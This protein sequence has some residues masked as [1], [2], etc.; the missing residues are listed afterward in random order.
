VGIVFK[1][2]A[3]TTLA[4][5]ITDTATSATVVDGSVFPSLGAG[6]YFFCT[7]DTGTQNEIVKVTARSGNTLTIVRAQDNTTAKAFSSGNAAELRVTAGVLENIQENIAAKSA[8]QTI[9]STTTA[10]SAT[11][12]D[13]GI[14]PGVEA[15]ASVF[16][17]GVYQHHDTFSFSGSTLTFDAAPVDGTALEVIVDNLINLQSSNLSVDTFTAADVGGNPQTDFTLSDVPGAET[18]LIVFVDGVFQNQDSYTFSNNTL[19]MTDGVTADRVVTVYIINPVNIGTPSDGTITSAK[20]SGDITFPGDIT[21]TG[22]VAFDSPTFVVDNANSRVGIGTAAP[23]TLLDIVGDVKMSA[24]LTVDTDSLHVDSANNRV[25]IGTASPA[26]DLELNKN[27][28]N[29]NLN[30]RSSDTGNATLLLGDQSDLSVASITLDNSSND[31]IFKNNNQQTAMTI[32]SSLNVGIGNSSPQRRLTV[33]DGSGS[34]IMSIYAGTGSASALHFTDTNTTTDFQGFVTYDHSADALR[35]GAAEAEGMR[36]TSTGLG[37]GTT[38]P[39]TNTLTITG[40]YLL[41][42]DSQTKLGDNGIIGGG[43]ADGNSRLEYFTGKYFSITQS[44]TEK[45]RIDSSGI[46][47]VGTTDTNV[48]NNSGSGNDG[49]NIHPDSI[50][51]ARTDGD[52]MLLNRLNTDGDVVKILKDGTSV[53]S[54]AARIGDLVIGNNDVGLRF[55]DGGDSIL[56]AQSGS[57]GDRDIAIDLGASGARFKSLYLRNFTWNDDQLR[58][59]S[60]SGGD[61]DIFLGSYLHI[62]GRNRSN[63]AAITLNTTYDGA[64]SDDYTPIYSGSAGAGQLVM[65]QS[66]GGE[67]SLRVY[68]KT[69]GTN[70]ASAA[71]STFTQ[72]ADFNDAGYFNASNGL[73]V[74]GASVVSTTNDFSLNGGNWSGNDRFNLSVTQFDAGA[75]FQTGEFVLFGDHDGTKDKMLTL[76]RAGSDVFTVDSGGSVGIGNTDP[77]AKLEV[78]N[79]SSTYVKLRNASTGDISSGYNIESGST[80]TTSLYGN[81]SEGWTTLLS[82]GSLHF[83]VNNAVS[84]FN[85]LNITTSSNVLINT[86]SSFSSG[87][88]DVL[89]GTN[90]AVEA[91]GVKNNASGSYNVMMKFFTSSGAVGRIDWDNTGS[92]MGFTNLSDARLKE[93][94]GEARGLDLITKLNPVK[95]YFKNNDWESEGL[96]A[97]EVEQAYQDLG[98]TPVGVRPP[99]D[100]DDYYHLSTGH[101]VVNLIKAVQE[102]QEQIEQLK[103]R[104]EELE[105]G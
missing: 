15:N 26:Q 29:V 36:L 28:A 75:T 55:S 101:F 68:V 10:S 47:S 52:M 100:E 11:S 17:D 63:T 85:A 99:E 76:K 74:N 93:V 20:L 39:S 64:E 24:D 37:I 53:G 51:V 13:I 70:S 16:L 84:G 81:A 102:Q 87:K 44:G 7:F 69:H 38:S 82:G 6:E 35:F 48:A 46:L 91:M 43:A 80:T 9:Y 4:S 18:N 56:P 19:T 105:N 58:I 89:G 23:S 57:T 14:D 103:G 12:Y 8:N 67:G 27:A 77:T 65:K 61:G 72:I 31:L 79:G 54:L 78:G 71:L 1:N 90:N 86:A 21:V 41:L 34:E 2:N 40:K 59:P 60:A 95:Y 83:R 98:D 73:Y 30:I 42:S 45:L 62:Y 88:L 50:R 5:G 94:T 92:S 3:K 49:V 33:G 96:V 104:I 25:G 22:D 97:Q 32:D 66:A